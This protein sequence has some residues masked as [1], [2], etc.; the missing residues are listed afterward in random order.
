MANGRPRVSLARA[1]MVGLSRFQSNVAMT[2]SSTTISARQTPIIHD[3]IFQTR[4][5]RRSLMASGA[6]C[7][8]KR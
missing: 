8:P 5:M 4:R 1:L 7:R 2:I 3:T 6:S